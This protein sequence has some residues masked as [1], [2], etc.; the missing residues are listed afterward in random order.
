MKKLRPLSLTLAQ[1]LARNLDQARKQYPTN[2]NGFTVL[3]N[4]RVKLDLCLRGY[5]AELPGYS[6]TSVYVAALNELT[7]LVRLI[8]EG[9][10]EFPKYAEYRREAGGLFK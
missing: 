9:C 7:M 1:A 4:Q 10:G 6:A 8:E 5:Q 2:E 3:Q